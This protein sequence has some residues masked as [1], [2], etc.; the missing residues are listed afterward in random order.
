MK[1]IIDYLLNY[2]GNDENELSKTMKNHFRG[3][4]LYLVNYER[5]FKG[6]CSNPN[7]SCQTK[8]II[9]KYLKINK[10]KKFIDSYDMNLSAKILEIL[11]KE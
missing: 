4:L 10:L 9:K 7:C 1:E 6:Y 5:G 11:D 2:L 8:N 3:F